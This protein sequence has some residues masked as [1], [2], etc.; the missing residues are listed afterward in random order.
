VL[1]FV[2]PPPPAREGRESDG[3][4]DVR[5]RT[6]WK[7]ERECRLGGVH[8]VVVQQVLYEGCIIYV[9]IVVCILHLVSLLVSR[10]C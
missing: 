2:H 6:Y 4:H 1:N 10:Y 3:S 9:P 7:K 8:I 5:G